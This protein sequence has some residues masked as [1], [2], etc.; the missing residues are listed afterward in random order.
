MIALA[1]LLFFL[2]TLTFSVVYTLMV[3]NLAIQRNWVSN[4]SNSRSIHDRPVPRLGGVAIFLA[5]NT[6]LLL[7]MLAYDQMGRNPFE[8]K[9]LLLKTMPAATV[10]FTL[11]L[12]D[13]IVDLKAWIKF[14]VQVV[15]A[16]ML[17]FNGMQIHELPFLSGL[18]IHN[19]GTVVSIGLT[20]LWVVGITN[21]FNLIDGLDGLAAGS[22]FFATSAVFVVGLISGYTPVA[23]VAVG[24]V[25]A[26]TGF[27]RFNFH[28]ASIFLGDSGSLFL[29]FML[30]ALALA[31]VQKSPTLLAVAIPVVACGLPIMD[32]AIAI[33]RRLLSG[34]PIFSSDREHI[35]HKLMNR[36][37]SQKQVVIMLYGVSALCA[38]LSLFLL[39]PGG[40]TYAIVIAVMGVGAWMG[41]Q[42][43]DY[44]ELSELKRL[45]R[46]TVDQKKIIANNIAVHKAAEQM[47][48]VE[49]M[50]QFLPLLDQVFANN[51]F[52]GYEF[53]TPDGS[54]HHQGPNNLVTGIRDRWQLSIPL[55]SA[56]QSEGT[57]IIYR[58]YTPEPL[59]VDINLLT[60]HFP[61]QAGAALAR[62]RQNM[63][64][65]TGPAGTPGHHC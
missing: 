57:L 17:Y 35:H 4:H 65:F 44:R 14:I 58:I 12:V 37:L 20:I 46:R 61:E 56:E 24:L 3:R 62:A 25:A 52:D 2:T 13:D 28:P 41:L 31:G 21:A 27:L 1:Y 33:F 18:G 9:Q 26:I 64:E 36:G 5:F 45:A 39:R 50:D 53:A 63:L 8:F 22:A 34:K 60:T 32:T 43:L 30:S 23:L 49:R 54:I 7:L 16:L 19:L 42:Q 48:G 29:G 55:N 38:F 59:L 47:A 10:I 11:G 15:A 51:A 6:G 40:G